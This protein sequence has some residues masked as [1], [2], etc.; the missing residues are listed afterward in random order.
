[1]DESEEY[2]IAQINE[3]HVF[4]PDSGPTSEGYKAEN[5]TKDPKLHLWSGICKVVAKGSECFVRLEDAVTGKTFAVCKVNTDPNGPQAIE[6]VVDSSRFFVLRIENK[7]KHAFIGIGFKEKSQAFDFNVALQSHQKSLERQKNKV[8]FE[9]DKK[10]YSMK[11]DIK[12]SIKVKTKGKERGV[13][14]KMT[15]LN[16]EGE[17]D[18]K[19][20]GGGGDNDGFSSFQES[21]W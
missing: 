9:K 3:V 19:A 6:K 16:L 17:D 13:G 4:K 2:V 15:N 8:E 21:N 7:D 20:T 18:N 11:G 5:W 10:D 1:M 14:E 12:V